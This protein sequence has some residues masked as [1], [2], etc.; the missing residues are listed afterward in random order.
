MLDAWSE[1]NWCQYKFLESVEEKGEK[2]RWHF[3]VVAQ[4]AIEAF[5]RH[6]IDAFKFGFACHDEWGD[7]EEVI[8]HHDAE[9]DRISENGELIPGYQAYDEVIIPQRKSGSKYG[10]RYEEAFALEA[11]LQRRNFDRLLLRLEELESRISD[12]EK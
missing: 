8:Q 4:R 11:K 12:L 1:V 10:I 3:G 7:Q 6:G 5:E 9:P 2:A